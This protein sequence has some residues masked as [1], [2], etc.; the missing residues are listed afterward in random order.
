MM[1]CHPRRTSLLLIALSITGCVESPAG[2]V[3]DQGVQGLQGATGVPGEKGDPG[4]SISAVVLD[5][6]DSLCPFG[7]TL[8]LKNGVPVGTACNGQQGI[9]AAVGSYGTSGVPATATGPSSVAWISPTIQLNVSPG[10]KVLVTATATLGST[11]YGGAQGLKLFVCYA[12]TERAVGAMMWPGGGVDNL[13]VAQNT[14]QTF[15][16]SYVLT[17]LSG[18]NT[19][20]ICG[21]VEDAPASNW[22]SNDVGYISAVVMN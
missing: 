22:N 1:R 5:T 13:Q 19:I 4:E 16:L 20:G 8:F 7:G 2:S 17:G 9:V 15:T 10:Q 11:A 12:R 21:Y 3:E 14:R 18:A 6:G